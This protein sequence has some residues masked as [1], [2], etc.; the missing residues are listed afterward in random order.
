MN[1]QDKYQS[2]LEEL[3]KLQAQI[4]HLHPLLQHYYP[5]VIVEDSQLNIFA[6]DTY[7]KAY[8]LQR[9]EDDTM[10]LPQ[11]IRAAFPMES[12]GK[13]VVV[14]TGDVF[15]SIGE[16]V[17][18]FHENVHCYQFENCEMRLRETIALAQKAKNEGDYM[19]ELNYPFPYSDP[20][21][22]DYVEKLLTAI[23][24]NELDELL[25]LRRS[26]K[27]HLTDEQ[28]EYMVWQ[29]WKEGFARFIENRIKQQLG[30]EENHF[31]SVPFDRTVFYET[32]SRIIGLIHQSDGDVNDIEGLYHRMNEDR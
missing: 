5:I 30:M 16:M 4:E 1:I 2:N 7:K 20:E 14:V 11:G 27:Q 9:V 18:I 29:E 32:G 21:Y 19:W 15:D 13:V 6:Y 12:D 26:I 24:A 17:T 3:L 23:E 28:V 25:R 22:V 31:F 10:N 8:R